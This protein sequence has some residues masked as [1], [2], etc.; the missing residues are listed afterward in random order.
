MYNKKKVFKA[1]Y[2]VK[3]TEQIIPN[4]S[5]NNEESRRKISRYI[6]IQRL[7]NMLR[8]G[9]KFKSFV[10]IIIEHMKNGKYE[11]FFPLDFPSLNKIIFANSKFYEPNLT[12]FFQ[13]YCSMDHFLQ[14]QLTILLIVLPIC[15][16]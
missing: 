11:D 6:E 12:T 16:I 8:K 10:K 3:T 9:L 1:K 14:Q 2:K 5:S 4:S 13:I 15:K 7:V